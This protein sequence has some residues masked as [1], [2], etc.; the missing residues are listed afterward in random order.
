MKKLA[1]I[2]AAVAAILAS[3]TR[4]APLSIKVVNS[5]MSRCPEASWIDSQEGNLKW[6]YTTGLE[7]KS[8][9]DVYDTYGGDDILAY[10]DAWYDAIIDS[11]GTI[12]TYSLENYSTD[13]ICP[14]RAL[15][16]LWEINGKPKYRMALDTLYA[17]LQQQPRTP[18]G[19]FWHK[20]VYP[21]QMWLDGLYMA[22]PF[23]A[24][25]TRAFVTDSIELANNYRDIAEQFELVYDHT[26]DAETGLLRHAWDS[27]CEMFWADPETGCSP[28]AWGRAM[29]WYAM[30]LVDV[31]GDSSRRRRPRFAGASSEPRLR[32]HSPLC[33]C[34]HGDVVPGPRLPL[35]RGQLPGGHLLGHVC[36]RNAEGNAP[37]RARRNYF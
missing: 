9:L 30:A 25:Y 23:Y 26:L 24:A 10:V 32:R 19:G 3:C 36:L 2:L 13:H 7:L 34:R 20:K 1:F 8:F 27:S 31:I 16:R 15:L 28:H 33:R 12:A 18:E 11:T 22:Q 37:W 6:N 21:E 29:G 4:E 14:G 17:Q 5:E 35:C